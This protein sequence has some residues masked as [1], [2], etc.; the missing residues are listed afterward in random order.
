MLEPLSK[1]ASN[2]LMAVQTR[3]SKYIVELKNKKTICVYFP[4]NLCRQ[5]MEKAFSE[6]YELRT[7]LPGEQMLLAELL[8]IQ[9]HHQN[10]YFTDF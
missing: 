3:V 9:G 2:L 4:N 1:L 5:T 8:R 10:P 6:S 7:G